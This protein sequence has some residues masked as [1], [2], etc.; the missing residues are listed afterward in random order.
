VA[1]LQQCLQKFPSVTGF[2]PEDSSDT[3]S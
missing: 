3:G 2:D 1:Q